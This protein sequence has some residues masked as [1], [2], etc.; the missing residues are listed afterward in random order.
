M[1]PT[2]IGGIHASYGRRA[3]SSPYIMYVQSEKLFMPYLNASR[4][5]KEK[6][7]QQTEFFYTKFVEN[8]VPTVS[9]VQVRPGSS[10]I[11]LKFLL[12]LCDSVSWGHFMSYKVRASLIATWHHSGS[13]IF[14]CAIL[15]A[16]LVFHSF[17]SH[18]PL[19]SHTS[20]PSVTPTITICRDH[21]Q[22]LYTYT[23]QDGHIQAFL[24][25]VPYPSISFS[26][27]VLN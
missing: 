17:Q 18:Q 16:I 3:L 20:L 12:D 2:I 24:S 27:M 5:E 13:Y 22:S 26:T 1:K 9:C 11:I 6:Q 23:N 19:F 21:S 25:V 7:M 15:V 10:F 4:E 8:C 14:L